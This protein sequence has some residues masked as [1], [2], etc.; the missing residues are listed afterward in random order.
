MM[1]KSDNLRVSLVL[2]LFGLIS[3]LICIFAGLQTYF[4]FE[5]SV[6]STTLEFYHSVGLFFIGIGLFISPVL[7]SLSTLIDK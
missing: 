7:W 1:N 2:K 6:P 3:T 4:F 5:G